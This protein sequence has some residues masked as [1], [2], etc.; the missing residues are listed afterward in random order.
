MSDFQFTFSVFFFFFFQNVMSVMQNNSSERFGAVIIK[1]MC[2]CK[3]HISASQAVSHSHV[4]AQG[5]NFCVK[6][7]VGEVIF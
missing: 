1:V 4:M 5:L 7:R 6:L 3:E 2:Y